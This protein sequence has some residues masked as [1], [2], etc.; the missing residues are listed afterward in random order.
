VT[1]RSRAVG[2]SMIHVGDDLGPI[3]AFVAV[4]EVSRMPS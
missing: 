2:G 4:E 1:A 3:G